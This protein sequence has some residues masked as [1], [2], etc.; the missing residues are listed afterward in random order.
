MAGQTQAVPPSDGDLDEPVGGSPAAGSPSAPDGMGTDREA[1][2]RFHRFLRLERE[3]EGRGLRGRRRQRDD[4]EE[5]ED[6]GGDGRGS[7]GPP[8][9]WDG[10]TP[11]EDYFIKAKL[12]IATTKAKGRSRGP[13]LLKMLSGAPFEHYKHWAKDPEWMADPYG[14]ERLLNDMDTP[15][16]YGDDQQEHRY[17]Q[18]HLPLEAPAE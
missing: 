9:S 6:G 13:L 2:L 8:P 3:Q 16:K 1:F 7:A 15:E 4:D 10:V 18:D 5:E 12:W 14:A 11:F 17:V